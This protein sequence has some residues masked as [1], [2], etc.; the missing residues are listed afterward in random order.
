MYSNGTDSPYRQTLHYTE[1]LTFTVA[2]GNI[3]SSVSPNLEFY[4]VDDTVTL[5]C[6]AIVSNSQLDKSNWT[7]EYYDASSMV[8]RPY[9]FPDFVET[10]NYFNQVPGTCTYLQPSYLMHKIK[11]EDSQKQ[12]RCTWQK[13]NDK[14]WAIITI[15]TVSPDAYRPYV[16]YI[17]TP[18]PHVNAQNTCT[19]TCI[20]TCPSP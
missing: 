15:G 20:Y 5:E 6:I 8:W 7:W 2:S 17:T 18:A 12:Y 14:K 13:N 11:A 9:L 1:N 10:E 19:C 4:V 3:T 16:G